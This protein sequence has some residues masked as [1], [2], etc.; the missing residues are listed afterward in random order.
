MSTGAFFKFP[1]MILKAA[2]GRSNFFE[3]HALLGHDE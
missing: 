1:M 2:V 3:N